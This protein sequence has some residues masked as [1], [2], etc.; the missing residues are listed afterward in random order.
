MTYELS[1]SYAEF[2]PDSVGTGKTD[3]FG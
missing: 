2:V 1:E 3:W